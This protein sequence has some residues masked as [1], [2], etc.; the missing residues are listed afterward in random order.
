MPSVFSVSS[1]QPLKD[2]NTF[3]E[4]LILVLQV[5][6]SGVILGIYCSDDIPPLL[7]STRELTIYFHSD[8]S[9]HASGFMANYTIFDK[10]GEYRILT[11]FPT[12]MTQYIMVNL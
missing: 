7:T 9:T 5:Y 3:F 11:Y 12:Q 4:K 2:G 6:S 10:K 1:Q 8:D